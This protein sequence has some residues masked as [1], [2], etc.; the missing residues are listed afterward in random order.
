MTR[1]TLS[2]EPT[3][4]IYDSFYHV[5]FEGSE[6]CA[7]IPKRHISVR[8]MVQMDRG[9]EPSGLHKCELARDSIRSEDHF[10]GNLQPWF[11]YGFLVQQETKISC[12]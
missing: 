12:T 2:G 7:E 11:Y 10:W 1:L 9:S 3:E 5:A 8:V 4:S 6:A